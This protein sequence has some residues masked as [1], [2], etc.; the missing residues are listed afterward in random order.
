MC[1]RGCF[2]IYF[3]R[4]SNQ[5]DLCYLNNRVFRGLDK[6]SS[7]VWFLVRFHVSLWVSGLK[8]FL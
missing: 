3:S 8:H 1:I 7:E 6:D 4:R 5:V 2:F